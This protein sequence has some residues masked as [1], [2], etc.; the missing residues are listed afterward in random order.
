[1]SRT[2][3]VCVVLVG[4]LLNRLSLGQDFKASLR[5]ESKE[6]LLLRETVQQDLGLTEQQI[7]EV[8][9]ISRAENPVRMQEL[10][11]RLE[12]YAKKALTPSQL[13][14]L[15]GIYV[16]AVGTEALF[17]P[18]I[19]TKLRLS[20]DQKDQLNEARRPY[21]AHLSS[22]R[23]LPKEDREG[24]K[25]R[26]KQQQALIEK[27]DNAALSI[28]TTK[29]LDQFKELRGKL[30]DLSREREGLPRRKTK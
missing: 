30:I 2:S 24:R 19:A 4:L 11:K 15:E 7:T 25:E 6:R 9:K 13:D 12:E 27:F 18:T 5:G 14:R 21:I 20:E 1:M 28:L 26:S 29:Q 22:L 3:L 23:K 10:H 8:D 16:Q 17:N